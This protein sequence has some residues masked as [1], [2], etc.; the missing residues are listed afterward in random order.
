MPALNIRFTEEE[1]AQLRERA[2]TKGVSMSKLAHD[3]IVNCGSQSDEAARW[4][5]AAE[6]VIAASPELLARLADQ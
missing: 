5:A 1:L 6:W 2:S 3:T 4:M